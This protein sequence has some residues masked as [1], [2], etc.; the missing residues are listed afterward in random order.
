VLGR[1]RVAVTRTVSD[2]LAPQAGL[3]WEGAELHGAEAHLAFLVIIAG[4]A[5]VMAAWLG[6][7]VPYTRDQVVH[8]CVELFVMVGRAMVGSTS[9]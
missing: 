8:R 7:A 2:A 9:E 5:E 4:I 6:G 3:F 1:V